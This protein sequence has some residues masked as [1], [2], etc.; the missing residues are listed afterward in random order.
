MKDAVWT[1]EAIAGK[2]ADILEPAGVRPRFGLLYLHDMDGATLQNCQPFTSWLT[3]HRIVCVCPFGDQ[4]WWTDRVCPDFDSSVSAEKY[5]IGSVLDFVHERWGLGPPGIG[6]LGLGMG[7]QGTLRLA[8]RH[9]D[10]FPV[11]AAVAPALE[12]H[13]WYGQ[14]TPLDAMYNSKEQARQDTAIM[15]IAPSRYPPHLFFAMDPG[16]CQWFRGND[17]LDE[18]LNALGVAHEKDFESQAQSDNW[19]Y[20]NQLAGR[21]QQFLL[22]GLEEQ[23]RRLL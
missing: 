10:L 6:L 20:F 1:I 23:S 7:G 18:K 13:E 21:V 19:G 3:H 4:T 14:G 12:Y 8:F 17:R 9:A 2:P 15:H 16:D 5:V 11:A 22:K